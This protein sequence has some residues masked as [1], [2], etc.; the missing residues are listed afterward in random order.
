MEGGQPPQDG[1][2]DE[3]MQEQQA[4]PAPAVQAANAAPQIDLEAAAATE[5]NRVNRAKQTNMHYNRNW[6]A[7]NPSVGF[8]LLQATDKIASTQCLVSGKA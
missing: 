4:A 5:R 2:P 1:N 8:A 6:C 3:E 7:R